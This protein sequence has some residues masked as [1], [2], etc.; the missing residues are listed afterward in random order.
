MVVRTVLCGKTVAE[1]MFPW[2]IRAFCG[3]PVAKKYVCCSGN[4]S[5]LR[6]SALPLPA[7]LDLVLQLLGQAK[8]YGG[9]AVMALLYDCYMTVI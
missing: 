3:K 2:Y 7:D 8:D 9:Q 4:P 5:G 6:V 1:Q